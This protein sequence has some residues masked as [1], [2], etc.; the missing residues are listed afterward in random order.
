MTLSVDKEGNKFR[1]K[2]QGNST[3]FTHSCLI[4]NQISG[5]MGFN[6]LHYVIEKGNIGDVLRK[7]N[8]NSLKL[9]IYSGVCKSRNASF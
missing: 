6:D 2:W 7:K 5:I 9:S 8:R 3:G 4:R 1:A